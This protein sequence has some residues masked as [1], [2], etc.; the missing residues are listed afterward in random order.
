MNNNLQRMI[1]IPPEVFDKWKHIITEDQNLNDLDRNMKKILYDKKINNINKWHQYQQI[2]LKYSF[3]K[4]G[5]TDFNQIVKPITS[6]KTIQTNRIP[7]SQKYQQTDEDFEIIKNN[8]MNR[9]SQTDQ[10][11]DR[12]D[13]V[14]ESQNYSDGENEN[15]I[16]MDDDLRKLALHGVSKDVRITKERRSTDPSEYKSY[17]LSNGEVVSVP[18]VRTRSMRKLEDKKS[19]QADHLKHLLQPPLP[20]KKVKAPKTRP[21]TASGNKTSPKM[22]LLDSS[23]LVKWVSYK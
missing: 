4:K 1:M 6:E 12:S 9:E 22:S 18:N 11:F 17:E 19:K 23:D 7:K 14:F 2:L 21:R 13:E 16:D 8:L 20:F 10:I 3:A 5:K 15:D